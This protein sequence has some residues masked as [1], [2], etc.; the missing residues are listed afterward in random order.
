MESAPA[1]CTA[2]PWL[3]MPSD[4]RSATLSPD[5]TPPRAFDRDCARKSSPP[6]AASVPPALSTAPSIRAVN[7]PPLVSLPAAL[8]RLPAF[9]STDA[10]Y[11][12][13]SA[14]RTAPRA[15]TARAPPAAKRPPDRFSA[16][17]VTRASPPATRV[18]LL[19]ND[20]TWAENAPKGLTDPSA[21]RPA[22]RTPLLSSWRAARSTLPEADRPPLLTT[23]P[24]AL[25][26]SPPPAVAAP[27]LTIWPALRTDRPAA[28]CRRP[29]DR[30]RTS[31]AVPICR[32]PPRDTMVPPLPSW[33]PAML[34]PLPPEISPVFS[35]LPAALS[36]M[37]PPAVTTPWLARPRPLCTDRSV[38]ACRR[39]D[40]RILTSPLALTCRLPV[41]AATLP[42][43]FTPTPASVPTSRMLLA[44]MPPSAA[45]SSATAGAP[46][47]AASASTDTPS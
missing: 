9:R 27:S 35:I 24:S 19:R 14:F 13:P 22:V 40:G 38:A 42:P 32:A 43:T 28:A 7:A 3:S 17:A 44:Y 45:T 2:P 23:L 36:A 5:T 21:C 6:A 31:P 18:P 8:S 16:S 12:W 30:F 46:P 34:T 29:G 20:C 11:N 26:A 41:R 15:S 39:P 47:C 25:S 4:A 10:P 33:P 1:A 37:A